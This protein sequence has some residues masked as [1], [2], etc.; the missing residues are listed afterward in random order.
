MCCTQMNFHQVYRLADEF[1]IDWFCDVRAAVYFT[2]QGKCTNVTF[3]TPVLRFT[4]FVAQY[5][6]SGRHLFNFSHIIS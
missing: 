5:T 1:L 4:N 2:I 3:N 6:Y